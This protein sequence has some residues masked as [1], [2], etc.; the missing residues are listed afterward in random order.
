VLS[1]FIA[2]V[3]GFVWAAIN[4]SENKKLVNDILS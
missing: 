1:P 2:A 4:K 3:I